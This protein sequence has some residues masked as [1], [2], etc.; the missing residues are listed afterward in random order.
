LIP[1]LKCHSQPTIYDIDQDG[2]L[3]LIACRDWSKPIIWD[4]YTWK[5]DTMLPYACLEPPAIADI[6]GDGYVEILASTKDNISIFNHNYQFIGSINLTNPD[7]YG[8]SMILAQD[9]DNDG[10][11]ELIINRVSTIYVYDTIAP[12]PTP[13]ALSQFNFYSQHR[14]RSPY[15]VEYN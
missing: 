11:T 10:L 7:L 6:D 8:M 2:N 5:L 1:N 4:L 13:R 15:Y 3:E 14:G 12:S 9:V